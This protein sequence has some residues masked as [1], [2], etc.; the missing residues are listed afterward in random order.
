M[1]AGTAIIIDTANAGII[2][3][4]PSFSGLSTSQVKERMDSGKSC[5]HLNRLDV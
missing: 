5:V 1:D 4:I 2:Q 3:L